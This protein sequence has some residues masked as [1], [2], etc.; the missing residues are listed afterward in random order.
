MLTNTM[1]ESLILL[2]KSTLTASA[3][4]RVKAWEVEVLAQAALIGKVTNAQENEIAVAA[5]AALHAYYKAVTDAEEAAKKPL[6]QLRAEVIRV[7]KELRAEVDAE[8]HRIAQLTGDWV[9][10]ER[11]RLVAEQRLASAEADELEKR[12]NRELAVPGLTIEQQDGIR[13]QFGEER[14]MTLSKPVELAR[15]A[16]QVLKADWEITVDNTDV[17]YLKHPQCVELKPKLGVIKDMLNLGI[18]ISGITAKKITRSSI[19]LTKG[20]E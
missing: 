5:Q 9:E 15:A 11:V 1:D 18:T 13:E 17:L 3:T 20:N 8:G 10:Q 6:N 12:M 2:D 19:R 16:G 4:E 7:G 14:A